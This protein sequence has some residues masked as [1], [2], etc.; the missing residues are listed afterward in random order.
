MKNLGT[1]K[2]S[3]GKPHQQNMLDGEKESQALKTRQKKYIPW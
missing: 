1:Q 3:I 2:K